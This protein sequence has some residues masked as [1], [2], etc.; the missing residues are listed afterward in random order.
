MKQFFKFMFASMLG[1]FLLLMIFSMITVGIVA[2]IVAMA[3]Q[4]E[5]V[6]SK[7]TVILAR[8]N[9]EIIIEIQTFGI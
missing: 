7:N 6:V 8:F 5:V 1:T 3:G 9:K 4:K 2:G